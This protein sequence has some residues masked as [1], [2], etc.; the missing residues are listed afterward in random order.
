MYIIPK[1]NTKYDKYITTECS[2]IYFIMCDMEGEIKMEK[3]NSVEYDLFNRFSLDT[4]ESLETLL[5]YCDK[6]NKFHSIIGPIL[7]K[8]FEENRIEYEGMNEYDVITRIL[9]CNLSEI[10]YNAESLTTEEILIIKDLL[11]SARE[12]INPA[13]I[14]ESIIP[15]IKENEDALDEYLPEG[16]TDM[17]ISKMLTKCSLVELDAIKIMAN[18]SFDVD[19]NAL[20]IID[21]E[22]L[23]REFKNR[24]N[25]VFDVDQ[26]EQGLNSLISSYSKFNKRE[27]EYLHYLVCEANMFISSSRESLNANADILL[28]NLSNLETLINES[29]NETSTRTLTR[30]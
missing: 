2:D 7:D 30:C 10:K 16:I 23:R 25:I 3:K 20:V 12:K 6:G 1:W 9:N 17:E 8:K 21:N 28:D 4:L 19:M 18:N 13:K 27:L 11:E 22:Y 15:I 24:K 14:V 26:M 29:L 5:L